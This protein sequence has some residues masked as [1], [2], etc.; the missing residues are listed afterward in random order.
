VLKERLLRRMVVLSDGSSAEVNI[1]G[2]GSLPG[3]G[4]A[5]VI[6]EAKTRAEEADV[7]ELV[8]KAGRIPDGE[9][10]ERR[11][12]LVTHF[13][14]PDVIEHAGKRGVEVFFTY[15]F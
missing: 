2:R 6:G 14:E 7:E 10:P 4:D 5:L 15:E 9:G 11:I 13:C 12:I 8:E 1:I 3:G